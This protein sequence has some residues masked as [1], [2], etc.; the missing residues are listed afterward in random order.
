MNFTQFVKWLP[1][2]AVVITVYN[3]RVETIMNYGISA[4]AATYVGGSIVST[5]NNQEMNFKHPV[6]EK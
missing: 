3:A 5:N 4:W 2:Y 1:K 6:I